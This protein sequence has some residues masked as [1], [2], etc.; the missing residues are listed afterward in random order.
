MKIIK[1]RWTRLAGHNWRSRDK[2]I[3]DVLL[4]TP[5]HG[6]AK[7]RT[8]IQ[9]LRADMRCSP[10]DLLEVMND[11]EGWRERVWDIRADGVTCWWWWWIWP[12]WILLRKLWRRW[13]TLDCEIPSSPDTLIVLLAWS[14]SMTQSLGL[15]S[16]VLGLLELPDHQ[17]SC[18]LLCTIIWQNLWPILVSNN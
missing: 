13:S 3:S 8:Y 1:I 10:E 15:K 2:L 17:G 6:R 4:W 11:K 16:K 14:V 9:Q 18:N 5:S 12:L 7:A